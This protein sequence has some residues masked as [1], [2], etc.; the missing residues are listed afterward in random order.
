MAYQLVPP[1]G[2]TSSEVYSTLPVFVSNT[3]TTGGATHTNNCQS[4]APL[5]CVSARRHG[6]THGKSV[7]PVRR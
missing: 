4:I 6:F 3:H 7:A 2:P 1:P 5:V